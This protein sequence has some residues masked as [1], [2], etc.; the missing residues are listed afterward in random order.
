MI[1]ILNARCITGTFWEANPYTRDPACLMPC[2]L[3][4]ATDNS[5]PFNHT[6]IPIFSET[7]N[8]EWWM[9][10]CGANGGCLLP[11]GKAHTLYPYFLEISNPTSSLP[12]AYLTN[13][14]AALCRGD[15]V[16]LW[17]T[18]SHWIYIFGVRQS[19]SIFIVQDSNRNRYTKFLIWDLCVIRN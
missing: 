17:Y 16:S 4:F 12:A 8:D 15:W 5:I 18:T 6:Y 13:I 7:L 14:F 10:R 19:K 9:K 3:P 1:S 2:S 11:S